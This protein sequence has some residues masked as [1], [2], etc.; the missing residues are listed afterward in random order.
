MVLP[1]IFKLNVG[2]T[3][4]DKSAQGIIVVEEVEQKNGTLNVDATYANGEWSGTVRD[5]EGEVLPG[6]NILVMGTT[7]GTVSNLDG[8]F[9]IKADKSN[10]LNISFVGYESAR[11]EGK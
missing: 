8:T 9:R 2:K 5:P 6:A 4:E 10:D 11:V 3:N 7:T 1:I